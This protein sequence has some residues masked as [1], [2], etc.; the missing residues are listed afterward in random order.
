MKKLSGVGI[1]GWAQVCPQQEITNQDLAKKT[2]L[3][4]HL[5]ETQTG[6]QKRYYLGL[7]QKA[8]SLAVQASREALS[9][10]GIQAQDLDRIICGTTSADYR[11]PAMACRIQ[12]ELKAYQ[13]FSFDIASSS[14]SFQVALDLAS[15]YLKT[16]C[17]ARFVL[18]VMSA[19][20]SPFINWKDAKLAVILGDGVAAVV[21]G[22]VSEGKGILHS[23]FETNGRLTGAAFLRGQRQPL[24]P[25]DDQFITMD[26]VAMGREFLKTQPEM[27]LKAL[28]EIR[29][30]VAQLDWFIFHQANRRLIELVMQKLKVS[31]S[32]TF[33]TVNSRGNTAEASVPLTMIEALNRR[34]IRP[35]QRVLLSSV[36]AGCSFA[37]T[38]LR[39]QQKSL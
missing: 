27:I 30:T 26:G 6:I 2:R 23:S 21:V 24:S 31:F 15:S 11:F 20:Q 5:I 33:I 22:R 39:W 28:K 37:V 4:A 25:K 8:E 12:N 14:T 1:V 32:K 29:W 34:K 3:D 7:S 16:H 9:K 13:A 19:I 36:G 10:A 38:L 35:G 18:L 17:E